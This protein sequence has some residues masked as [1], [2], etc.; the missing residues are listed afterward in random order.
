MGPRLT[1]PLDVGPPLSGSESFQHLTP[2]PGGS[3]KATAMSFGHRRGYS[4]PDSYRVIESNV[5]VTLLDSCPHE[6]LP[7]PT[8]QAAAQAD[9]ESK[10]FAPRDNTNLTRHLHRCNLRLLFLSQRRS[11]A[12]SF[13]CAHANARALLTVSP[14]IWCRKVHPQYL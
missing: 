3:S 2:H 12:H 13:Q 10:S 4:I 8:K 14:H 11:C 9:R 7:P 1:V 6:C 5:V